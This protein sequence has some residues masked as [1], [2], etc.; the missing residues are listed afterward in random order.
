MTDCFSQNLVNN[1]GFEKHEA[2]GCLPCHWTVETFAN[3]M[4]DW[5]N[6]AGDNAVI[7]DCK[8]EKK[9][10]ETGYK[11]KD[12]C[13]ANISPY[14]GC[15]M[16]QMNY[17]A[18]CLDFEHK[19]RGCASYLGTELEKPLQLGEKYEVSFWLYIN[20]PEDIDYP[21]H[22]GFTLF[23][24]VIRNPKGAMLWQNTFQIDTVIY[25][26]WYKVSWNI[27]PTCNLQFL[28]LGVFRDIN[29]PAVHGHGRG[30]SNI[31]FV[32]NINVSPIKE[33]KETMDVS[34]FC[35]N[36]I[37]E[38]TTLLEE[39]DGV[40]CYFESGESLILPD[41]EKQ[42]DSFALRAKKHP[43]ST[44]II[45]GH[46]DN[47]GQNHKELSTQRIESVLSYLETKHSIPRLR[48]IAIPKGAS[49][50]AASN[51]SETGRQLNRCVKVQQTDYKISTVI[52]RNILEH[53]FHDKIDEAFKSLNIWMHLAEH[54][55]KILLLYDPRIAK[56]KV[57]PRWKSIVSSIKKSY[58][59]NASGSSLTFE[60]DKLWAEDQKFRTLKFYIEN[61]NT[62]LE[63]LDKGDPRWDVNFVR[64]SED[65]AA[66]DKAHLESLLK[67]VGEKTWVK[68]S[69]VG[70]RGAKA[71]FFIVQHSLDT[72][73]LSSYLPMLKQRC[74]EGESEWIYYANMYDRLEVLKNKPQRFGTQ[75]Q[76]VDENKKL[77]PLENKLLVNQWRNEIGLS[78]LENIDKL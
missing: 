1:P 56:L 61:L 36:N 60:L 43:S 49:G 10:E 3:T 45:S 29:G 65:E 47:V 34:L 31:Y 78:P 54:N 40:N 67:L 44:F 4:F 7:C 70:N 38:A 52:Y 62:Y 26:Q 57:D 51:L 25:N 42:L 53:V 20:K 50:S 41:Y 16:I 35:K 30:E 75:F 74:M 22:I 33:E 39:I 13:P 46:T 72:A 59:K 27:Q 28:V 15:T 77:F 63:Y 21:Q 73:L 11:Y 12:I 71:M 8:Y 64:N 68:S 37:E 55:K 5:K 18:S 58:Q 6:L 76:V 48:F 2:L 23:P 9:G 24:N 19:T 69:V 14:K 66:L 17:Q 32:D